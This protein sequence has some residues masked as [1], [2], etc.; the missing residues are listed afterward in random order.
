MTLTL[1]ANDMRL[2]IVLGQVRKTQ[3]GIFSQLTKWSSDP[4]SSSSERQ[5]YHCIANN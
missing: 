2:P 1:R 3:R 5:L 4:L